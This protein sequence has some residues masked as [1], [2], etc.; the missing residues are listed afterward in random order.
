VPDNEFHLFNLIEWLEK[1]DNI[2]N[3]MN[4]AHRLAFVWAGS[5]AFTLIQSAI[6]RNIILVAFSSTREPYGHAMQIASGK[7]PQ[8]L[9]PF[10]A[11]RHRP[12]SAIRLNSGSVSMKPNAASYRTGRANAVE[13]FEQQSR[14]P[15]Q[16]QDH[17]G[18][19]KAAI[20]AGRS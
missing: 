19:H 5:S 8:N 2:K 16:H 3:Y 9:P 1:S 20:D 15:C 7:R 4:S 13:H 11:N 18:V 6:K 12:K 17:A 14:N 10:F